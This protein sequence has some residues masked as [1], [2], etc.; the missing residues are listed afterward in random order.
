[1]ISFAFK[2]TPLVWRG[3][4]TI[5]LSATPNQLK[6]ESNTMRARNSHPSIHQ[7]QLKCGHFKRVTPSFSQGPTPKHSCESATAPP[8]TETQERVWAEDHNFALAATENAKGQGKV[9]QTST[10]TAAKQQTLTDNRMELSHMWVHVIRIY[11]WK[12]AHRGIKYFQQRSQLTHP[13][14]LGNWEKW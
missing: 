8:E 12:H 4:G 13:I 11:R 6:S 1:V 5:A 7:S 10:E 3:R 2:Q 9:T 14:I